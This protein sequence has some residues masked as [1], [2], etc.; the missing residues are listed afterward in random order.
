MRIEQVAMKCTGAMG[1][2]TVL[3]LALALGSAAC[4]KKTKKPD[5]SAQAAST[6]VEDANLGL[7]FKPDEAQRTAINAL[8]AK[9]NRSNWRVPS[10]DTNAP[11]N[12]RL[13]TYMAAT[14]TDPVLIGAG[15]SAMY[16]AYSS[17]S[18]RKAKPDADYATVVDKHLDSKD[19]KIATRAL[20]AART[21]IAGKEGNLALIGKVV[22]LAS[23][24][25]YRSGPGR[26]AIIDTLRVVSAAQRTPEVVR[27]F[28]ESLD[29]KETYVVSY[30]LQALYRATRSIED[31][32][33]LKSKALAL[34]KHDD[35]GVR[36]RAIELLGTL[37]R[38]DAAVLKLVLAALSDESPYVRSEA[39]ESVSRLRHRPAMH[40]LIKL[41]DDKESNRYDIRDWTTLEG[42][43]GRLHHDGSPWSRVYD[44]AMNAM[45]S[46]SGGE[47]KL[48]KVNP[49]EIEKGLDASAALTKAWYAKEKSKIPA[50]DL[51]D[52][53]PTSP[54]GA[55][56][57]AQAPTPVK[58]RAAGSTA[59]APK[60][61]SAPGAAATTQ[62]P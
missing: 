38:D 3:A 28:E 5:D 33:G 54:P 32:D 58:P 61:P 40:A 36:G 55:K 20:L 19:P 18:K 39:A 60:P 31:R 44:A 52:P 62:A 51:D 57:E 59:P 50:L 53:D 48:E 29:S 24:D 12:A 35:P 42:K 49:K 34:A 45:R 7:K 26:Y 46:L 30:A 16:G 17:H 9:V 22:G 1:A 41:V 6:T 27:V 56:G 23:Q 13:F 15:L 10:K 4:A 11:E 2:G 47:L 14:E 21:G 43:P 8:L 25:P 37:G